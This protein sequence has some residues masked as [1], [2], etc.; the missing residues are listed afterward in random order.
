VSRLRGARLPIVRTAHVLPEAMLTR[1]DKQYEECIA[2]G[3]E[4]DDQD[5]CLTYT[6]NSTECIRDRSEA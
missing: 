6:I 1:L 2:N 5:T 4:H 3:G